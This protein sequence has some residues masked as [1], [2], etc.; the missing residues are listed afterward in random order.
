MNLLRCPSKVKK[1]EKQME[2]SRYTRFDVR[3]SFVM[4]PLLLFKM[5][6]MKCDL[7]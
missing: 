1:Q 3:N 7:R 5:E 4:M 6:T 2:N